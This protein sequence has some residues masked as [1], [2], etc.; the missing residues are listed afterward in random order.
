MITIREQR[1]TCSQTLFVYF[2]LQAFEI[3]ASIGAAWSLWLHQSMFARGPELL[4]ATRSK[5]N[6][7]VVIALIVLAHPTYHTLI[8]PLITIPADLR[9]MASNS[10]R[11]VFSAST[12]R[13]VFGPGRLNDLPE[14]LQRLGVKLP[15]IVCSPTRASL[16]RTVRSI[17]E[18]A[19]M[20]TAGVIDRAVVHVPVDITGS[21]MASV[22][23]SGADCVISAGGGSAVGLGKAICLRTGLPHIC[24]PTTY[25]GSEMTAIL[26]ELK[27]GR[28]VAVMDPNIL[29]STVIYD[30]DLTMRLPRYLSA[31]SGVNA[32]AHSGTV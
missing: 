4:P 21:S 14:E 5:T 18:A 23:A 30:V 28:K 24:I 16:A 27:D 32:M 11:F 10:E 22:E 20:P 31:V 13:V 29:P 1:L 17:L 19:S 12:P 6:N 15:V 3:Y 8:N 2:F 25:S 26:G 7:V 9:F